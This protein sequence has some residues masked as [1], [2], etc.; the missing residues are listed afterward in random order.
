MSSPGFESRTY[1]TAVSVA[2]HYNGW[3]TL[4]V[5]AVTGRDFPEVINSIVVVKIPPILLTSTWFGCHSKTIALT[6]S[7]FL[8]RS[9]MADV[10]I[11]PLLSSSCSEGDTFRCVSWC[12]FIQNFLEFF[13]RQFIFMSHYE[14]FYVILVHLQFQISS[15]CQN[16]IHNLRGGS[17][18][19]SEYVF[20]VQTQ[21]SFLK[22]FVIR[23]CVPYPKTKMFRES[24]R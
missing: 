22:E 7:H 19:N 9:L 8:K 17:L 16:F 14:L 20:V 10:G 2:N 11:G 15:S 23:I 1:G 6:A 4:S 13:Y 21:K 18:I 3:A 5:A 12:S 24:V